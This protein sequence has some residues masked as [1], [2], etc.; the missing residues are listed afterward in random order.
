MSKGGMLWDPASFRDP[1]GRVIKLENRVFR[2]VSPLHAPVFK[3]VLDSGVLNALAERRAMV[4][5]QQLRSSDIPDEIA[6]KLDPGAVVLEHECIAPITYPYEWPWE[7]LRDAA[8]LHLDVHLELLD[9]GFTLSDASAFNIQ[10]DGTKP[11]FIDA[12]SVIPNIEG[13]R[14]Q[15]YAQFQSEFLNPL[16]IESATAVSMNA[17]Y[18]GTLSGPSSRETLS[19][20]PFRWRLKPVTLMHVELPARATVREQTKRDKVAVSRKLRPLSRKHFK[21]LLNHL[22]RSILALPQPSGCGETWCDYAHTN[23]YETGEK[24]RKVEVIERWSRKIRPNCLLDLGCNIGKMSEVALM[25][26][27]KRSIGLD[28]DRPSLNL[29]FRQAKATRQP[30]LPLY[31]DLANPSPSQ[32]WNGVERSALLKRL[33]CDGVLALALVHHLVIGRNLPLDA[34]VAMIVERARCG[35]IEFVPKSDPMV[36]TL[37]SMRKDIFPDYT[38][39]HFTKCLVK[40][41]RIVNSEAITE[42]GRTLFEFERNSMQ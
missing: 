16:L 22:R 12:L 14:W 39:E 1:A 29:C 6:E 18:R 33:S 36:Q 23:S 19:L 32:G 41:A 9:A 40:R 3:R 31:A 34:V 30:F 2:I 11:I 25:N 24:L 20:L 5:T 38:L 15:G 17:H 21:D 42:S 37:L 8:V 28:S 10:F 26:G 13:E 7:A 35:L 27:T 4:D